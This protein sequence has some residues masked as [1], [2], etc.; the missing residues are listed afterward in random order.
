MTSLFG[1][2]PDPQKLQ[3]ICQP[4]TV[5][6]P[7]N[8]DQAYYLDVYY[9]GIGILGNTEIGILYALQTLKQL[10]TGPNSF[11]C[12]K[13]LDWPDQELR[14]CARPLLCGEGNRSALAW[15]DGRQ[16]EI[17]RWQHEIDFALNC[18]YN[19]M[20]VH[21]FT[22]NTQPYPNFASE[23]RALNHYARE[24]GVTLIFG[25][26]GIGKGG[27]GG[28][29]Y[30][31]E[32]HNFL[33]G[34]GHKYQQDYP[35]SWNDVHNE[36]S[37]YNG[38]CRSNQELRREKFREIKEFIQKVE[39]G[40]LYIHHEDQSEFYAETQP[41]FWNKRCE[42]CRKKWPND[43]LEKADGGAGAIADGYDVFCEARATVKKKDYDASKDCKILLASPCYGAWYN[44]PDEWSKVEELW[45]NISRCMK[46][47]SN[48]YF[49]MREQFS[50]CEGGEG[51]LQRLS[52]LI[53][54]AGCI[55]K[56][57]VFFVS[58]GALY[59]ENAV[60]SSLPSFNSLV[61][62]GNGAIFNFSGVLF[63]RP[64]QLFNSECSWNANYRPDGETIA[65]DDR[66]RQ[67]QEYRRRMSK[68]D[69]IDQRHLEP[70]GFLAKCCKLL[71][72]DKAGE[73]IFRYQMLRT[74]HGDGP[75]VLLYQQTVMEKLFRK[76]NSKPNP[77][78]NPE[79]LGRPV[80][81]YEDAALRWEEQAEITLQGTRL[82]SN[83][84]PSVKGW[85][86][87]ELR[88]QVAQ[89]R[90]GAVFAELIGKLY[91]RL[92]GVAV[93]KTTLLDMV[94]RLRLMMH[95]LPHDYPILEDG[96]GA[97]YEKHLENLTEFIEGMEQRG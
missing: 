31:G 92:D 9:D 32:A 63:Q 58:G 7:C 46:Y 45:V 55:Q 66:E 52:R 5:K 38:T 28:E 30:I 36:N 83:A 53:N 4:D 22:W 78:A 49:V 48:V 56:L 86:G 35:C 40:A 74:A 54:E 97:L 17:K 8:A 51:R 15:G 75:L 71:Y 65:L 88:R 24:R 73:L 77:N 34:A 61:V 26:Y 29:A 72:G 42:A 47:G 60:F 44:S 11:R 70:D 91:R 41:F 85:L 84:M 20:F 62:G 27:W 89:L 79:S 21:G 14:I 25:G 33:P 87:T 37:A 43:A 10:K 94:K 13:I 69:F 96:D 2:A 80:L 76:L 93:P 57:M 81:S 82:L 39:P 23:M 19:G 90:I 12:A 64:Q 95:R 18:R 67:G 6:A 50:N 3:I 16:E 1:K 59:G 68:R